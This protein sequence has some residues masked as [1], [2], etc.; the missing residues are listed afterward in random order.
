MSQDIPVV[1]EAP[2]K[3][4]SR[5]LVEVYTLGRFE[6]VKYARAVR[7]PGK[8]PRRPLALLKAI[9]AHGGHNVPEETLIS[10][11]WPKTYGN[12]ARYSLTSAIFRLRRLLGPRQVLLRRGGMIGLNPKVCWVDIWELDRLLDLNERLYAEADATVLRDNSIQLLSDA[13]Q[14]YRG[15]FLYGDSDAPWAAKLADNLRRRML[16]QLAAIGDQFLSFKRWH[17]AALWYEKGLSID[18][19]AEDVSRQLMIAY[20]KLG[21]S[22]DILRTYNR[23]R[24]SLRGLGGLTPSAMT[25]DLLHEFLTER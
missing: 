14:L 10:S 2:E 6:I 7:F 18:P 9:I 11:L 5:A 23:C 20:H 17:E 13:A 4:I 12:A 19:C 21:R 24:E 1:P 3:V 22:A 15:S 16:R 25:E 8:V